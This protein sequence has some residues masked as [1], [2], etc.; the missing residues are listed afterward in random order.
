MRNRFYK[1]T[2]GKNAQTFVATDLVYTTSATYDAF[3]TAAPAAANGTIGIYRADTGALVP[4]TAT[5][6]ATDCIAGIGGTN[7][8]IRFFVAQV[9]QGV[10]RVS[11]QFSNV[12]IIAR[13]F[14]TYVAPSRQ[15]S[16]MGYDYSSG[17]LNLGTVTANQIFS[18]TTIET[19]PANEPVVRNNYATVTKT[20]ATQIEITYN[21]LLELV[22]DINNQGKYQAIN[23]N[24]VPNVASVDLV[25]GGSATITAITGT[26]NAVFVKNS[27]T[28]TVTT[29]NVAAGDWIVC[30]NSNVQ[31]AA[32]FNQMTAAASLTNNELYKVLSTTTTTIVLDRPYSGEN[33]TVA[34]ANWGS[35]GSYFAK[36]TN[37]AFVA[38]TNILGLK[39]I[40]KE[41]F[42]SF[43]LGYQEAFTATTVTYSNGFNGGNGV[44][45][46]I[47]DA[48]KEGYTFGGVQV[49][50]R[51]FIEDFGIPDTL[52][53]QLRA[54]ATLELTILKTERSV[55]QP[56]N[57]QSEY[58]YIIF[59]LPYRAA[60]TNPTSSADVESFT[61]V[62]A[63][64]SGAF[65]SVNA[66]TD[67]V[68]AVPVGASTA[69][70]ITDLT[71][72]LRPSVS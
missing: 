53:N 52:T 1:T 63:N 26:G 55:A 65:P 29:H 23:K 71:V 39:F 24:S 44:A 42:T 20:A 38:G 40:S 5:T 57:R 9:N 10:I 21:A 18:L 47:K 15:I 30:S 64:I 6:Y 59:Y 62:V 34:V 35:G 45:I 33:Q 32:T 70:T 51:S 8:N 16:Y 22:L 31:T 19:T 25:Y 36:I 61:T 49:Y 7:P 17:S 46:A 12:D 13:K 66:T 68:V 11:Q 27:P 58:Q 14:Q 28:I 37:A 67:G 60:S 41:F 56:I 54:Y 4:N 72:I 48:E 69:S 2:R 43:R 50:N 3:V